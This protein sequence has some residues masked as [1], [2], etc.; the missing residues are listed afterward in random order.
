MAKTKS[1]SSSASSSKKASKPVNP[2]IN[3]YLIIYN[4]A[5][6]AGWAYVLVQTV[7]TLVETGYDFTKVYAVIGDQLVWVQTAA[8]LEVLHAM[9]GLV[10]SP[11]STTAIQVASRLLLVWGICTLFPVP[12]VR[13]YW[14]FTTMTIAWGITECIRYAYYALNLV[15]LGPSWL[16]WCRYTFFFI[17]YPVGAGSEAIEVYQSLPFAQSIHPAY[18]Y[19]LW[20]I[21]AIYP[22][23][24]FVMYTHMIGQRKRYLGSGKAKKSE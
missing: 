19:F 3:F 4:W 21:I 16:V 11:V 18:Y 9:L 22:P 13:Q 10:K 5:S 2:V 20:A 17:L 12:E 1:Q 23:G 15:N 14:G 24:F 8:I 6:F 7:K